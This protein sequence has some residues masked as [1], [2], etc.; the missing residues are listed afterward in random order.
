M[1]KINFSIK[2]KIL[3][4]V[5]LIVIIP[6][7]ISQ[8]QPKTEVVRNDDVS[9][10]HILTEAIQN[11]TNAQVADTKKIENI[12]GFLEEQHQ[13]WIGIMLV[14]NMLSISILFLVYIFIDRL[15]RKKQKKKHEEYINE[16]EQKL[17]TSEKR[18]IDVI[19]HVEELNKNYT[20]IVVEQGPWFYQVKWSMF[21]IGVVIGMVFVCLIIQVI[22][23]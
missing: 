7:V 4:I 1:K 8:E 11:N 6:S 14:G 13:K 20:K 9:P 22:H 17:I 12:Y 16:L 23:G 2:R 18:I 5:A 3:I 21:K 10:L 15:R 19:K